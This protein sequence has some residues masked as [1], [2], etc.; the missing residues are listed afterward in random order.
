M[1]CEV[2]RTLGCHLMS[3]GEFAADA[4]ARHV[5]S[6]KRARSPS[7]SSPITPRW[8][9]EHQ[10]EGIHSHNG[11]AGSAYGRRGGWYVAQYVSR[12]DRKG[13]RVAPL[14]DAR[15]AALAPCP[16]TSASSLRP[17]LKVWLCSMV[18]ITLKARLT[19]NRRWCSP[20][21]SETLDVERWTR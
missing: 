6:L 3:F 20:R 13:L 9:L 1:W 7:C 14:A 5:G 4:G 12:A 21:S 8:T 10:D 17:K 15:I 2:R 19:V 11:F 16:A 18:L